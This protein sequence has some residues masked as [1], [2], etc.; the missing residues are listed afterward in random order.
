MIRLDAVTRKF[1]EMTAVNHVSL[2]IERG[3]SFALLGPNGA[4]KTTIV[5]ML[6]DFIKPTAGRITL[7]GKAVSDPAARSAV[8]YLAESHAIPPYLSGF[9]YL[10]RH[11]VLMGLSGKKALREID[12]VLTLTSM[13]ADRNLKSVACSKGMRQRL[14][15]GAAILGRP[16]C[17]I[18]D[19]PSSGLDPIG[20]RD[21]RKILEIL[22][23]RKVTLLINSHLLSEVEKT[24]ET[25]G[26]MQ[27]GRILVKGA[28]SSI[29]NDRETLEDVFIRYI[30]MENE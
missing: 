12:R 4:G 11:A 8:G 1:G 23:D 30:E 7:G 20:M 5:R 16:E 6:L 2:S 13:T 26:I 27:R 10:K 18:L 29:A 28:V 14:G 3:E 9:E 21:V 25:I 15:L 22:H 19:E 24:C 17:L